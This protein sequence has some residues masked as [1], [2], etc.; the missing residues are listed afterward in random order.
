MLPEMGQYAPY[1]WGSYAVTGGMMLW[2]VAHSLTQWRT[3]A[4]ALEKAQLLAQQ[5]ASRS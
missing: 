2:L 3:S 4:K 5:S 1:I